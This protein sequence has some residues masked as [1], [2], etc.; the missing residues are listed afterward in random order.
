MNTKYVMPVPSVGFC[1]WYPAKQGYAPIPAIITQ[2]GVSSV[3][4]TVWP[5]DNRG[6]LPKDGVRH[7]SDPSV[8]KQAG[9]DQGV[10]DFTDET[11]RQH[12]IAAKLAQLLAAFGEAP[13]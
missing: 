4:L 6:G 9:Y 1:L 2:V 10:W 8:E 11:K 13:G 3:N 7:I 12:E 5:P